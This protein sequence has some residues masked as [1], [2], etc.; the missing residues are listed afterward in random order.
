[1]IGAPL[2]LPLSRRML[3]LRFAQSAAPMEGE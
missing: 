2:L 1:L 3:G